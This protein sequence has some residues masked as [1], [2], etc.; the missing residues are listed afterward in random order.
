LAPADRLKDETS[1]GGSSGRTGAESGIVFG[2]AFDEE[3]RRTA[4]PARTA[5]TWTSYALAD[6]HAR[7]A[8]EAD[9]TIPEDVREGLLAAE[10]HNHFDHDD[11]WLHCE[12]PDI[13]HELYGEAGKGEMPALS[14]FRFAFN[15][16]RLISARRQPLQ[17][18]DDVRRMVEAGKRAFPAPADVIEAVVAHFFDRLGREMVRIGH[19][20]DDIED[21]IVGER[22]HSERERL[23]AVRRRIV[24]MHRNLSSV[25]TLF[26]HVEQM[27]G[28]EL[29]DEQSALVARLAHRA[30][31]L[32]SESE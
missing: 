8:I 29:D 25:S 24:V 32:N 31:S 9:E 2:F 1:A 14:R 7:R 3:G 4:D 15:G 28:D 11:G 5:W 19:D 22:W 23:S 17:S 20:L 10:D 30:L 27:H 26:R 13:Q 12:V 6:K 16:T 18:V 21:R